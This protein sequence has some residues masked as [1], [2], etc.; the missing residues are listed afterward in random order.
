MT[1]RKIIIE[2][3]CEKEMDFIEGDIEH[4]IKELKELQEEYKEK[5]FTMIEIMHDVHCYTYDDDEHMF[6][7]IGHRPETDE[8]YNKRIEANEKRAAT[9]KSKAERKVRDKQIEAAVD[10]VVKQNKIR[11]ALENANKKDEDGKPKSALTLALEVLM[12]M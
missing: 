8:E 11:E 1:K 10:T 5:G 6:K 3:L 4:V 2:E 9:N 7:L 12:D